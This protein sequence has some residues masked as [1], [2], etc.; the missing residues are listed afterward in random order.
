MKKLFTKSSKKIGAA[1]GTLVHIGKRKSEKVK[2]SYIDYDENKLEEKKVKTIEE[3]FPFKGLP[4]ITWVNVDGLHDIKLIEKIGTYFQFHPLVMED[5]CN[6]GQRPKMEDFDDY[7]FIVLKML[8]YDDKKDEVNAEQVSFLVASNYIISFQEKEG[9]IFDPVRERL[10]N[11][12]GRIRKMGA[13][14]LAYALIDI[15]VDHYFT[16]I[17][18]L[19][20]HIENL[21]EEV[22]KNSTPLTLQKI[23]HLKKEM[24]FI[25]KSIW[26][27]RELISGLERSETPIIQSETFVFLKDVYDHTIQVIDTIESFRDIAS[28][29]VDSYL[30]SVSNRMN[31]IMKVLTIFA[32]IFIPLTFVAGIYGMN[33]DFMPELHWKWGYGMIWGIFLTLGIGMLFYFKKRKWL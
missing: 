31:E 10:R 2:I 27:L 21:E 5:V 19:G 3:V 28:G 23:N 6:T 8:T 11:S 16:I 18:K 1:P 20:E 29:M 30:S 25:R 7:L 32:A 22:I 13:D 24:L 12:K 15:I 9:D 14:Y 26:P 4:S 17:E 33:F